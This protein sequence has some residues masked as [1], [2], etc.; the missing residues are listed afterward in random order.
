VEEDGA[1]NAKDAAKILVYAAHA[2]AGTLYQIDWQEQERIR[3]LADLNKD[4]AVNSKDAAI[5]L[6]YAAEFGSGAFRR[7]LEEYMKERFYIWL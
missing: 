2:G 7:S 3:N 4:Y 5:V 1:V 6:Q